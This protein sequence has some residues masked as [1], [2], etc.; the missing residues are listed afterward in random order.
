MSATPELQC[1]MPETPAPILLTGFEPFDGQAINPS[2]EAV[3]ALD[4]ETIHGRR[5][6]SRMLPVEFDASLQRLRELITAMEP[7][8]VLCV[9]QA[10][11]RSRLSIERV[12]INVIDARIPDNA[13][14]CPIDTPIVPGGPAAF[15]ATL[16]IKAM[17]AAIEATGIPAEVS[18]TAGTYVCNSVFYGL[19]HALQQR[20][21]VRGGFIHIPYAPEQIALHPGT[22]SLSVEAVANALRIALDTALSV[23]VDHR[24]AGGAEH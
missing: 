1:A 21:G 5:V 15:F 17:Q 10:G 19:M 23:D 14:A 13:G 8:L 4:G 3:R 9:G 24:I 12:A 11:G 18:Q 16:P 20:P 6:V 2:W 22:P 7:A